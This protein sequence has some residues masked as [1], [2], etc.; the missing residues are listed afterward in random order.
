MEEMEKNLVIWKDLQ[1][2][3]NEKIQ[4]ELETKST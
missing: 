1:Q 4:I 2:K 3:G